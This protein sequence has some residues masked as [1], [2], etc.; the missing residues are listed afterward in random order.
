MKRIIAHLFVWFSLLGFWIFLSRNNHPT[1]LIDLCATTIL[2]SVSA[3][4]VYINRFIL[5]PNYLNARVLWK[6][7]IQLLATVMILDLIAVFAIQWIY[8]WLWHPDPM[9]F[10]LLTNILLEAIFISVHLILAT[11]IGAIGNRFLFSRAR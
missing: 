3:A 11:I 5:W 6:Y 8:D 7:L 2:V 1:L 9:R 10:G 4:T